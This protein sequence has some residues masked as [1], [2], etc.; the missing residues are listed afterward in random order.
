MLAGG[1]ELSNKA[2]PFTSDKGRTMDTNASCQKRIC[3]ALEVFSS[4]VEGEGGDGSP[5]VYEDLKIS[6]IVGIC[7]HV[8]IRRK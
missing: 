8:E 3:M 5:G 1:E 2:A 7:A 6:N 4:T